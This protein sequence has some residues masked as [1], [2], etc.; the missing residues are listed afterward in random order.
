MLDEFYAD[1]EK[2]LDKVVAEQCNATPSE[3]YEA[4]CEK[5]PSCDARHSLLGCGE[6]LEYRSIE[7]KGPILIEAEIDRED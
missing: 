1:L 3:G 4:L 6:E 2:S 5:L 7:R